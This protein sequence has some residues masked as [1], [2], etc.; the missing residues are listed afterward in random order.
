MAH[1]FR[2]PDIGEG[3]TEA[4]IIEW[5]VEVGESVDMDGP[6][7]EVET[8][9]AVSEIPAPVAGVLLHRGGVAGQ[10]IEVDSLLA[11]IGDQG[12]VWEPP[13]ATTSS[14]AAAP[15]VG[16][17][18]EGTEVI[19]AEVPGPQ[20]LPRV[21]KLA[22][23][24]G[25]DV[26]AL[27][28]SGPGGRITDA[29]VRDAA[30]ASSGPVRRVPMTPL[31]RSIADAVTRSWR[32]IPHVT[33]FDAAE[34]AEVMAERAGA[35]KPPLE[36]VV[37]RRIVPLLAEFPAFNAVV[38]GTDIVEKLHYDIG[39]AVDTPSGLMV[40]VV[41][42]A[43]QRS[44]DDLAAEIVRLGD[45]AR[46]RTANVADLRG[47]TFTVSNIGAVGGGYGTPII[48]YG[49]TAILSIGRAAPAPIVRDGQVAVGTPMPLSLS[50]DHRAIDGAM[51]RA[52]MEAVVAAL[53]AP[54]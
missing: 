30:D 10:T 32:E 35:G 24:L 40:G 11:V 33:I 34:A 23:D 45:A 25:V 48:P 31:R 1:E 52:F 22:A 27:I 51:G 17:L 36:A 13:P 46:D 26:D 7:V 6:L 49:T 39:V 8:D 38:A 37:I 44:L 21:R 5:F 16:S 53:E 9:K 3:L 41:R 4:T 18:A 50:Y 19:S 28:G 14:D 42:S 54:A 47:Q 12:E 2:L 29:D 15:I 43:D 20:M